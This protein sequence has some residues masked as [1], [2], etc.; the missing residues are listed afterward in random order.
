M[1][2]KIAIGAVSVIA[3]FLIVVALQPGEYRIERSA[4]MTA[5]AADVFAQVNDFHKWEAWSPWAK[6]DPAAKN[7]FDGP[8]SGVG[9]GFAWDGNDKVGVGRMTITESKPAER[10]AI[11]L[12][13][14]KPFPDVALT[15]F[16]FKG[17]A[18]Q[19]TLTWTMSGHKHY[20]S[21]MMCMFMNMDSMVGGEF[22][23]GLASI[24]GVV[25]APAKK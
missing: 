8:A 10:I 7:S 21:K 25:E 23:K 6:L 3:V 9:A 17:D 13:F 4:A 14:I 20:L 22:E 1:G 5:P 19:T 16:T 18:K 15:E 11:K 2:K 24:K 12:E